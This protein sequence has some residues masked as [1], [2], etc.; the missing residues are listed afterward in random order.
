MPER[1]LDD[2]EIVF[3]KKTR[4]ESDCAIVDEVWRIYLNTADSTQKQ[5]SFQWLLERMNDND[6][7]KLARMSAYHHLYFNRHELTK[8]QK[9]DFQKAI[10]NLPK[11]ERN[12]LTKIK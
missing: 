9:N 10:K 3:G 8:S 6:T 11:H 12:A 5:E 7:S 4:T 1:S 2:L